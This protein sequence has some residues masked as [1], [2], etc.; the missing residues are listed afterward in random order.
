MIPMVEEFWTDLRCQT[1]QRL[2]LHRTYEASAESSQPGEQR[3]Q[4]YHSDRT[5]D[6]AGAETQRD[7]ARLSVPYG[8]FVISMLEDEKIHVIYKLLIITPS[9]RVHQWPQSINFQYSHF[10]NMQYDDL[11]NKIRSSKFICILCN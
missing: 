6:W 1:E 9:R 5:S 3:S 2:Q 10:L 7:N 11:R 4:E 8:S